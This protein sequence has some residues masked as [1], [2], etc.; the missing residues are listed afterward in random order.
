METFYKADDLPKFP[1]IGQQAPERAQKFFD[2]YNAVF[3]EGVHTEREK[4][5]M[6]ISPVY[7]VKG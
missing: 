6:A 1:D 2:C 3:A 7:K 5:L 4:A